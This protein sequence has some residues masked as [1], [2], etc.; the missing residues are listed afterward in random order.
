MAEAERRDER[1][2]RLP[3][4]HR[5]LDLVAAGD[6]E[7]DRAG[8]D[9]A[10]DLRRRQIGDLDAG[11]A[12]DAA[13]IAPRRAGLDE[14]EPGAAKARGVVLLQAALGGDGEDQRRAHRPASD[15]VEPDGEADRRHVALRRRLEISDISRS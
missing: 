14:L 11:D 10:G 13:A 5:L 7:M 1:G 9:L 2:P 6:A 12:G 3:V 15:P 4:G 8:A